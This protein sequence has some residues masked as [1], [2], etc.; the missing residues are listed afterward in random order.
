MTSVTPKEETAM[1][2]I[3]DFWQ[4]LLEGETTALAPY[5]GW[6]SGG[7]VNP[8]YEEPPIAYGDEREYGGAPEGVPQVVLVAAAGA[9][10]KT[11]FSKQLAARTGALRIDLAAT[12][13]VGAAFVAGGLTHTGAI[14]AY[15][16]GAC[17]IV[18][19]GLDEARLRVNAESFAAFLRDVVA[20]SRW[21]GKPIVLL[22][23]TGSADEAWSLL[24]D[25]GVRPVVATIGRLPEDQAITLAT[26][27]ASEIRRGNRED[28]ARYEAGDGDAA[29]AAIEKLGE[30]T[31]AEGSDFTGYPPVIFTIAEAIAG[32]T[33]PMQY[34]QQIRMKQGYDLASIV[35]YILQREQKKLKPLDF[36]DP[37]LGQRLYTPEEQVTRLV[38]RLHE[39]EVDIDL[40]P[41]S[42]SDRKIYEGA[43]KT[44]I[45]DHPFLDGQ[46]RGAS[47]AVFD[48]YLAVRGLRDPRSVDKV[49][50]RLRSRSSRANPFFAEFYLPDLWTSDGEVELANLDDIGLLHGSMLAKRT[51]RERMTLLIE[52]DDD[53][54]DDSRGEILVEFERWTPGTGERLSRMINTTATGP[55]YLGSQ[56]EDVTVTGDT[57]EV[58]I[59]SGEEIIL[60]APVQIGVGGLTLNGD[61]IAVEA[62]GR[63]QRDDGPPGVHGKSGGREPR[64]AGEDAASARVPDTVRL[65]ARTCVSQLAKLPAL[66]SGAKLEVYWEGASA[67]PWQDH[68]TAPP[69][70]IS[71]DVREAYRR[72]F[73]MLGAFKSDG[74]GALAKYKKFVEHRRR[75]K[76]NGQHVLDHLLHTG[77]LKS[78]DHRFYTLDQ[79]RLHYEVGVTW[80]DLRNRVWTE[81]TIAFLRAAIGEAESP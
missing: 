27:K 32:E 52:G 29:R 67:F 5:D 56:V 62:Q 12:G 51:E 34:A 61:T 54:E 73:K 48:A 43:L 58:E 64:P 28:P 50:T 14:D 30:A 8:L 60:T 6:A 31:K 17:A 63:P 35:E 39:T 76:G 4:P 37:Q 71:E 72:L 69:Q 2:S 66:R 46:G 74:Y 7:T 57:L 55:I 13:E 15:R 77:V 24:L 68:A 23:R 45:P 18:I 47:T 38:A 81:R 22:G 79:Q 41:M 53:V 1:L 26:R 75:T 21:G 49:R 78:Q 70:P 16:S 3:A 20:V 9:V 33:N 80:D 25:Y 59:G 44:W 11:E 65:E 42:P 10:G 19:D 36:A 40:P